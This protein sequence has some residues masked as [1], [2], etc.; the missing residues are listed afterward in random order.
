MRIFTRCTLNTFLRIGLM[1]T[2]ETKHVAT[3]MTDNKI[4]CESVVYRTVHHFDN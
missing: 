2:Y 1:M 3:F 4:S